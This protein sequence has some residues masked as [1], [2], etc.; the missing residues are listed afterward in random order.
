MIYMCMYAD[1]IIIL[2]LSRARHCSVVLCCY[3]LTTLSYT[4]VE[5]VQLHQHTPVESIN[6]RHAEE[7]MHDL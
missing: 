4:D 3:D 7:K 5:H 2:E 1:F 6:Y